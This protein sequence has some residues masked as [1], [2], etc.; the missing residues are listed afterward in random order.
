[1]LNRF[2]TVAAVCLLAPIGA[3][4]LASA[5]P[6][7][8]AP[9]PDNGIVASEAP[10][11]ITTP[12]GAVLTVAAKDETQLPV[13]PLTT[14]ISSRE[15]LVGATYTGAVK[16][17]KT[18]LA[19]GTLEVGYQIGCGITAGK[20]KLNGSIG[21]N[22]SGSSLAGLLPTGF[23]VPIQGQVEVHL[24]PGDVTN[25]VVNKKEF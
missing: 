1:M 25:V 16:A 12:D 5:E 13:P 22:I 2:A 23:A 21:L 3:A 11:T 24:K 14:A 6:G 10:V 18:K 7:D 17:G 19:G 8:A 4:S 15:Y 20:V 9:P